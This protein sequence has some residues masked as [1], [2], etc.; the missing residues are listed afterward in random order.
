M[1]GIISIRYGNANVTKDHEIGS[2]A[3]VIH[4]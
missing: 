1:N 4:S 3:V 2:D